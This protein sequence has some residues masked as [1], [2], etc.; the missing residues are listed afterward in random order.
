MDI[1]LSYIGSTDVETMRVERP[2]IEQHL[3]T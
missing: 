1:D 2:H 3:V